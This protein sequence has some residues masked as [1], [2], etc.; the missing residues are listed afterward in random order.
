MAKRKKK[1]ELK[2]YHKLVLNQYICSLFETEKNDDGIYSFKILGKDFKDEGMEGWDNDGISYFYHNLTS[3]TNER[4]KLPDDKLKEYDNNI[5]RHTKKLSDA[6]GEQVK[7]KY[8]QYFTL[9]FVEIYLDRYFSDRESLLKDL[10]DFLYDFNIEFTSKGLLSQPLPLYTEDDLHVLSV[11][12]AT[13][14]GKTLL[15]HLNIFQLKHYIEKSGISKQYN[16]TILLTP[17]PGLS[18]QHLEELEISG[19]DGDFFNIDGTA[20][21]N[22]DN[23]EIIDIYKLKDS[24]GKNTV[25]VSAFNSN[26]IVFVDEG[27]RGA[28]GTVWKDMRDQLSEEGFAFEYSATFGQAV[29]SNAK[30]SKEYAKNI[31]FDYSYKYFY[32]DGFGKDYSIL[33][34]PETENNENYHKYM[35]AGLISFYQQLKYYEDNKDKLAVFNIEKPLWVFIGRTVKSL[36]KDLSSD[37]EKIVLFIDE[38]IKDAKKTKEYI[39]LILDGKLGLLDK[40]GRDIFSNKFTYLMNLKMSADDIFND[41]NKVLFNSSSGAQLH[42]DYLK[43]SEGELALRVGDNE[44]F[45]VI[46][47]GESKKLADLLSKNVDVF[48]KDFSDSLFEGIND[49]GSTI[50]LLIGSKKFSEGWNSWRVSTMG[51]LNVGKS[52][53]SEIIQLFGRGVRLKGHEMS[54]KRSKELV[55]ID[56]PDFINIA[57]TLNIFGVKADYMETFKKYLEEEGLPVKDNVFEIDIPVRNTLGDK[58]LRIPKIPSGLHFKTN[59]PKPTLRLDPTLFYGRPV[60]VNMY[61]QLQ[62]IHSKGAAYIGDG[63]RHNEESFKEMHLAFMDFEQI[64]NELQMFKNERAWFNLNMPREA[65]REILNLDKWYIIKIPKDQ[66][67]FSSF[68]QVKLWEEIAVKLLKKYIERFY[69]RYK[70]GWENEHRRIEVLDGNDSN[71]IVEY[72]VLMDSSMTSL[73]AKL[74]DIVSSID[75]NKFDDIVFS[76]KIHAFMFDWHLYQP[77]MYLKDNNVKI[78]PQSLV[79][80][81]KTFVSDLKEYCENAEDKREIYLLRNLTKS[82]GIGFNIDTGTFF[83]DFILWIVDGETQHIKFIDPKGLRNLSGINDPKIRFCK[84][85]KLL[86]NKLG[87]K[88]TTLDSYIVVPTKEYDLPEWAQNEKELEE[89]NILKQNTTGYVEKILSKI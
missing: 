32:N 73:K 57:E 70:S 83:P 6:R 54:L 42:V 58:K 40:L 69:N 61:A 9:L 49:R 34:L 75:N 47:V 45:G 16:K 53:G 11:W 19:I 62:S 63:I 77:L 33:N 86:E 24:S 50:N 35:T 84:D 20:Q 1:E 72:S 66:M 44:P 55:G 12:N 15:M 89:N 13:G 37:V 65:V 51:L 46:N 76:D 22:T 8:F 31:L 78:V 87:D 67:K 48:E 28:S 38:F 30:L 29:G 27:H 17:N 14:S 81:E 71:F 4:D 10:N 7:W 68:E 23:V 21:Y 85:I 60:E 18:K 80:S 64:Y 41:L 43:G 39:S 82:K 74:D 88:S 3:R 5:F 79:E 2:F 36:T 25:A 52:E 56:R 59:A 26:N